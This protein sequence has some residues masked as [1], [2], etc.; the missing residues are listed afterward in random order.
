M[1]LSK[2][3]ITAIKTALHKFFGNDIEIYLF[4]SRVNDQAKG[5]DVDLL[6][7]ISP[8]ITDVQKKKLQAITEMQLSIGEQKIDLVISYKGDLDKQPLVVS[9]AKKEGILL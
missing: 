1:R 6:I 4:G 2:G 9:I 3:N 5:G 7:E 8:G